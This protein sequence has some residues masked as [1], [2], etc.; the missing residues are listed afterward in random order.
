[1][2]ELSV[3]VSDDGCLLMKSVPKNTIKRVV[4]HMAM[5]ITKED[6]NE[7]VRQKY[8]FNNETLGQDDVRKRPDYNDRDACDRFYV[9]DLSVPYNPLPDERDIFVY[10]DDL[11]PLCGSAGYLRIRDGY[12]YGNRIVSRA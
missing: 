12:V 11:G 6:M 4:D 1:M 7:L 3:R 8:K 9:M 5:N 10:Y 2:S